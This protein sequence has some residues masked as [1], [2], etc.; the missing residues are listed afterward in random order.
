MGWDI[1]NS[2]LEVTKSGD[3]EDDSQLVK[4]IIN[5]HQDIYIYTQ[6]QILSSPSSPSSPAL[7]V[8]KGGV[9]YS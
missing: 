8:T 3:G 9:G 1:L 4:K 5:N 6:T 7:E 2:A